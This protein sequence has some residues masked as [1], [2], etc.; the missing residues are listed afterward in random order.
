V[1]LL[2]VVLYDATVGGSLVLCLSRAQCSRPSYKKRKATFPD[3]WAKKY[4][5]G[6]CHPW[7]ACRED[8][9]ATEG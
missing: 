9:Q 3:F 5:N 4:D 6:T 7:V 1:S 8:Q 2:S